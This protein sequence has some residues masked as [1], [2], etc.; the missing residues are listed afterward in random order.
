MIG[1]SDSGKQVGMVAAQVALRHAQLEL[2]EVADR[3]QLALTVFHG[4]G[5]ALGRGGGPA[6]DAIR[7]QPAAAVRGR[8]R[9][10]EQGET[11]TARYGR[12]EIARR[13]LEQMVTAVVLASVAPEPESAEQ[14]RAR[15]DIL[16]R[17]AVVARAEYDQLVGD[18]ERL[19]RYT[20]AATPIEEIAELP[21]ASRPASR[22]ARL[23]LEHLRAIPW[24]F[25]WAQSRHGVPGWFG[26]GTTLEGLISAEGAARVQALYREWPFFRALVDNAQVALIRADIDVAAEYAKLAEG[27]GRE[28]FALIEKEHARTVDAIYTV[29]GHRALMA[30]WPTIVATVRRRNPLVDILSHTQV[31]LLKRLR[32]APE[33]E[34]DRIRGLLFITINGIAAGLQTAG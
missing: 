9:V 25:S 8:L 12:S 33:A 18:G 24:V 20:L 2:V 14:E 31:A 19:A 5:G 34:R 21:I 17:A 15:A 32:A 13:D 3:E 10:T 1:Y 30:T 22:K 27:D 6:R 4:R 23:T 26:L 7:A 29:T 16:G 28:V 11:V